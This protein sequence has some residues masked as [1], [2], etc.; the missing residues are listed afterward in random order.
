M[1]PNRQHNDADHE[2]QSIWE[3]Y[4]NAKKLLLF[5]PRMDYRSERESCKKA[6]NSKIEA[7]NIDENECID[8]DKQVD[9]NNEKKI[10]AVDNDMIVSNILS[11]DPSNDL[12]DVSSFLNFDSSPDY[13]FINFNSTDDSSVSTTKINVTSNSTKSKITAGLKGLHNGSKGPISSKFN[14]VL[15]PSPISDSHI[16][17]ASSSNSQSRIN[18]FSETDLKNEKSLF[19]E[20]YANLGSI[21]NNSNNN[22]NSKT[23]N[24]NSGA[25]I[26]TPLSSA[27]SP[28]ATI[29]NNYS[30]VDDLGSTK[31]TSSKKTEKI[32]IDIGF[33][34]LDHVRD[35]G[36]SDVQMK[37]DSA[38]DRAKSQ[39]VSSESSNKSS[40]KKN[41]F[42]DSKG[43]SPSNADDNSEKN[44]KSSPR[45]S[46]ATGPETANTTPTGAILSS[47]TTL[48][49]NEPQGKKK[50]ATTCS[51]CKTTKTPLWRRNNDG[52]TLC[53]ACGLFLK[54]H[55]T[56]R[57]LTLKTD[58]IKKRNSKKN[59]LSKSLNNSSNNLLNY[60]R[61]FAGNNNGNQANLYHFQ[62]QHIQNIQPS[63]HLPSQFGFDINKQRGSQFPS[64]PFAN[65]AAGAQATPTN[66]DS[67]ASIGSSNHILILPKPNQQQQASKTFNDNSSDCSSTSAPSINRVTKRANSMSSKM[68]PSNSF[69]NHRH[70]ISNINEDFSSAML[71]PISPNESDFSANEALDFISSMTSQSN[72]FAS[73]NN[74]SNPNNVSSSFGPHGAPF[75]IPQKNTKMANGFTHNTNSAT[76]N[77]NNSNNNNSTSNS[78]V[79]NSYTMD[80]NSKRVPSTT[81]F[82]YTKSTSS[83]NLQNNINSHNGNIN[84]NN[85]GTGFQSNLAI[86]LNAQRHFNNTG[87]SN[88]NNN[89][90]MNLNNLGHNNVNNLQTDMNGIDLNLLNA[91]ELHHFID[92][93]ASDSGFSKFNGIDGGSVSSVSGVGGHG[94]GPATFDMNFSDLLSHSDIHSNSNTTGGKSNDSLSGVGNNHLNGNSNNMHLN[95]NTMNINSNSQSSG[96]ATGHK[97]G[98]SNINL[99]DLDWL[100]F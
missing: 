17:M 92:G 82:A 7:L 80:I 71:S 86:Q 94:H 53:N 27:E 56:M 31:T 15:L 13:N 70:S 57:P 46:V 54:L 84:N 60:G 35:D 45:A 25:G 29:N 64:R 62:S 61:G 36:S 37:I 90:S 51:N 23:D 99:K 98:S 95:V 83:T 89:N 1:D 59:L 2:D 4:S 21:N 74:N 5:K 16:S 19:R 6:Q 11:N 24:G 75:S 52:N 78:F 47:S 10:N 67:T 48:S 65:G 39:S 77:N 12:F 41:S 96:G 28:S 72:S 79:K 66:N 44:L 97:K 81:N 88:N 3:I 76:N 63:P 43:T 50:P 85:N 20:K 18:S 93:V 87:G 38:N 8:I 68:R 49:K 91:D 42:I 33:E 26:A 34:V 9:I 30:S 32:N 14:P 22:N 55:G 69:L 100:Q 73:L 58:V 40:E